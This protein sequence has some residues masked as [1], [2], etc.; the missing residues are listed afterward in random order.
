MNK[1]AATAVIF[2]AEA[3]EPAEKEPAV[4]TSAPSAPSAMKKQPA[5]AV[6]FIAEAAEAAE[7]EPSEPAE[8]EAEAEAEEEGKSRR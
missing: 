8:A 2:I 7:A 6:I 5:T 1:P 4:K 3:A